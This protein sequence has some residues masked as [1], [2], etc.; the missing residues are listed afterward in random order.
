MPTATMIKKIRKEKGLTQK[1]LGDLCG[2][3]DSNIRKYENGKQFPKMETLQKIAD[4]LGV[5]LGDLID[6]WVMRKETE[7]KYKPLSPEEEKK[8]HELLK[9]GAIRDISYNIEKYQLYDQYLS[10]DFFTD[11]EWEEIRRFAEFVKSK[12]K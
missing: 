9:E 2:I 1:Q 8:R 11:K 12:R 6:D 4:A 5:N 3:A 7:P 10:E